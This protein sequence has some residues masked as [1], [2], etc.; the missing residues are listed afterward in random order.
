MEIKNN[1]P[2][3]VLDTNVFL[4]SLAPQSPYAIIFD[5]LVEGYFKMVV[6]TEIISEYEE[7]IGQR[8]DKQTVN[9]I[10][11]LFLNLPNIIQQN[12]SFRFLLIKSDED[13]DKFADIAVAS[14]ADVI[15]TDDKHYNILKKTE[16]P[17]IQVIK[18]NEFIEFCK[19][20][21]N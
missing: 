13:D 7:I 3:V 20:L 19:S 4:V 1:P 15:V 17:K 5:C 9:D 21:R 12:H 6:S 14:N 11:E 8:Y 18:A 16:F 2:I 10:F